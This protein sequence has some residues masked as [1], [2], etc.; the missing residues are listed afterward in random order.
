MVAYPLIAFGVVFVKNTLAKIR[1][2]ALKQ[3]PVFCICI[4]IENSFSV[5]QDLRLAMQRRLFSLIVMSEVFTAEQKNMGRTSL[6]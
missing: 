2:R 1:I 3:E 5:R 4:K 6:S